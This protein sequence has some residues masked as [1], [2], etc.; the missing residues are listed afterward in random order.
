M[1]SIVILTGDQPRHKYFAAELSRAHDVRGA[2]FEKK[3]DRSIPCEG[4]SEEELRAVDWWEKTRDAADQKFFGSYAGKSSAFDFLLVDT[5]RINDP[6]VARWVF[7][8]KP[9]VL[10]VF[11]TSIIKEIYTGAYPRRI[12]NMHLG[13][14]PEYRGSGTTL[15]P[16]INNDFKHLGVSIIFLDAGVD[17]GDVIYQGFLGIEKSDDPHTIGAK[18]I[19]VGTGLMKRALGDLEKG[20]LRCEP[21]R[22]GGKQYMRKEWGIAQIIQLYKLYG[23]R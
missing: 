4:L 5:N 13:I 14:S 20:G 19:L 6:N 17:T 12:L 1:S 23:G 8:K 18:I 16:I 7:D 10:C 3:K 21:Q 22:P 11:G 9:D 15:W 2:I